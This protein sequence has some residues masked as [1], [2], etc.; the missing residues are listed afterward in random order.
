[1]N[2]DVK[3]RIWRPERIKLTDDI[4]V[5][6]EVIDYCIKKFRRH[7]RRLI[8]LEKYYQN[9]TAIQGRLMDD[10]DKPNNR[11]SHSFAK[12]I[13]KIAT[14]YFMGYGV[15]YEVDSEDDAYKAAYKQ[16]L[17]DILD[18]NMTKIKHFEEAKEMGKRGISYELL[19]INPEGKLKT[20]YYQANEMIPV[21]SQTPANFLTMV[22]RPY[23]LT[24]IDGRGDDVEYVDVYTKL[25]V[26]NFV[27]RRGGQWQL[28]EKFSHNFSDVPVIIRMNNAELKGDFE[29]VIPQIDT[30]DKAVSDTSNNLDYFSDAYLVFEGIDDLTATDED[31]NELSAT[32]SA[33]V[34]KENRTILAPSGCKPGF[35]T[36]DADDTASENHKNRTF[37]DIFF[38]SQ[39]P[40]LTDEEFAGNLSGVA[41]KYKLFGLEELCIEKETYFRSSETKKVRLITEYINAL[42]NTKYD[43]RDVKLSFDRSA[44]ANTYEAAQTINLLRDVLSEETL[45]GLYPEIDDPAAELE[46][47]QKEQAAEENT[48]T[49]DGNEPSGDDP[50]Q[51]EG[52]F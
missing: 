23:T 16:A 32:E 9:E 48:G 47:K 27:R 20:Q 17:D 37:K 39:V 46:K 6:P 15:K 42:Q 22:L 25:Y 3:N 34:M 11:V 10:P 45:I 1:M 49:G 12:Y 7:E 8:T 41:I 51:S 29:D 40:N 38:L 35:I 5:T 52:V 36:K 21:F 26:Y 30:Y 24:S 14:A 28:Q 19:F 33:K 31:G 2:G 50:G 13:T 44:V 4:N 43:W 18:S